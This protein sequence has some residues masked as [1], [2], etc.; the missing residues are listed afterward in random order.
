MSASSS[1]AKDRSEGTASR[2]S[3]H[4]QAPNSPTTSESIKGAHELVQGNCVTQ[5]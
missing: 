1:S 5:I 2:H 3:S 4:S